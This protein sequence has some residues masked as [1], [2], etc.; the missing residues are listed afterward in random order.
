MDKL[1]HKLFLGIGTGFLILIVT[2][3]ITYSSMREL[4]Y[5]GAATRYSL[6]ILKNTD[7]IIK[8]TNDLKSSTHLYILERNHQTIQ[9]NPSLSDLLYQ[10]SHQLLDISNDDPLTYRKANRIHQ[11]THKLIEQNDKAIDKINRNGFKKEDEIDFIAQYDVMFTELSYLINY[12][13]IRERNFLNTTN[14]RQIQ[15]AQEMNRSIILILF[16]MILVL[17]I[18]F[19]NILIELKYRKGAEQ[20]LRRTG[21]LLNGI[22]NNSPSIIFVKDINGR[23]ILVNNAMKKVM[24]YDPQSL[25][26]KT[27]Y[28]FLPQEASDELQKIDREI[29]VREEVK[30]YEES[31]PGINNTLLHFYTI[32]FPLKDKSGKYYGI[33]GISTDITSRVES[34][35]ELKNNLEF[36]DSIIQ[37]T[38]AFVYVKDLSYR[39]TLVNSSLCNLLDLSKDKIIGYTDFDIW[40]KDLAK[41]IRTTDERAVAENITIKIEELLNDKYG[42]IRH[43]I[44]TK[45]PLKNSK[46]ETYALCSISSDITERV[47]AEYELSKTKEFLH[48]I[49]E[50]SPSIIFTK[51]IEGKYTMV[52][53]QYAKYLETDKEACIGKTD[54]DFFSKEMAD[55]IHA[56]EQELLKNKADIRYEQ[57]LILNGKEYAFLTSKFLLY[58]EDNKPYALCGISTDI[59][60]RYRMEKQLLRMNKRYIDLYNNAPS[61]YHSV[62]E[63]GYFVDMND[64][65]LKWLG[66]TRKEVIGKMNIVDILDEESK[67]RTREYLRQVIAGELQEIHDY[68]QVFI[69]KDGKRINV[70]AN[71]TFYREKI[72]NKL[73][74]RTVI[75]DITERKQE[76]EKIHD[77][78]ISLESKNERLIAV[79]KELEAFTY[80]VSHDLRA[81]LRAIDGF[82]RILKEDYSV[83]F[84][85]NGLRILQVIISNSTKMGQLIDNL[86]EFSRLGKTGLVHS[87][88]DTNELL[89]EIEQEL[90]ISKNPKIKI[91][92]T[93]LPPIKGDKMM[94]KQVWLNLLS[95]AIKYSS[96]NP[97]IIVKISAEKNNES[98]IFKIRDEGVGFDMAYYKKLFNVF[99]RLHSEEEFE[100]MGVGLA[101]VQRIVARHNGKVWAE[102]ELNKGAAFYFSI[103]HK[104]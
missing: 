24:G 19:Y 28:D 1:R 38:P 12:L 73:F 42:N 100:G 104:G 96:Q 8:L 68:E 3:I 101:I 58:S 10:H 31:L 83:H 17:G 86:L 78:N 23:Y 91:E 103:P 55:Q 2:A 35:H 71:T 92:K 56:S 94:I 4:A 25:V 34:E 57:N 32:K 41:T 33:C 22:V 36:L 69:A 37:N 66:Y 30:H 11:L 39:Y 44:T 18:T 97:Q 90:G 45:F 74:S 80:S 72:G 14:N 16:L 84:D 47:Q 60:E 48:S 27:D 85:E 59:S 87:P 63:E 40:N 49:V 62:N 75:V 98:T 29:I 82:T 53:T 51:D 5:R 65:E 43:F 79:N 70:L 76:Q 81:P 93:D 50:Y 64:T 61:G 13:E 95:N 88:I 52:N 20:N 7:Q 77:L 9:H 99:Q 15:L 26:G 21:D 54:Y 6:D 46:A 89:K 67:R 102:S